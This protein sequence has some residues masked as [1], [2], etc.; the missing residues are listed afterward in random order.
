[1]GASCAGAISSV[2]QCGVGWTESKKQTGIDTIAAALSVPRDTIEDLAN[3][4]GAAL[5]HEVGADFVKI[6]CRLCG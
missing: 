1:M 6:G 5:L 4:T 2:A 3:Q